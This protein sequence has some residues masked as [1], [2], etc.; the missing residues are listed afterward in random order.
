MDSKKTSESNIFVTVREAA[1]CVGLTKQA[2]HKYIADGRVQ[3]DQYAYQKFNVLRV[4]KE[5]VIDEYEI[6]KE[7]RE[8]RRTMAWQ[9][10][11]HA[12]RAFKG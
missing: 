3:I 5:D 11:Y 1:K 4:N 7:L 8:R 6:R 12:R 9:K 10:R 2:V